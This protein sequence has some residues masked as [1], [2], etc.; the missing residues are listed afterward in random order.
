MTEDAAAVLDSLASSLHLRG[1]VR[2][3]RI[4]TMPA[5]RARRREL[6]AEVAQI[7]EPGVYYP[8]RAVNDLLVALYPDCAT[9]R[10]YL[11]DEEFLDRADGEY[12]RIGGP[13]E[14]TA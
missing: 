8:E 6:L 14:P 11:I 12:W 2:A 10:R 7:F 3:D 9:L 1:F 5:R 4:D 13:V